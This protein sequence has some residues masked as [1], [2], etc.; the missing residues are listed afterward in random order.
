M[1]ALARELFDGILETRLRG[2]WWW[3]L[4]MTWDYISLRGLES[5][6]LD[7]YDNP[8]WVHK[9]MRFMSEGLARKLDFSRGEGA[10]RLE[11][12]RRL[13]GPPAASAGRASCPRRAP[14]PAA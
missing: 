9:T 8:E 10:P 7:L 6:M 2:I 5:F 14:S 12:G 1:L 13:R 3:T 11:H 4:G